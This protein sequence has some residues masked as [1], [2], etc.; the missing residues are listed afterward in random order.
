MA[1][2]LS[3]AQGSMALLSSSYMGPAAGTAADTVG[4]I[5]DGRTATV[6]PGGPP[7][8][9]PVSGGRPATA[10]QRQ[11][12]NTWS[13]TWR[14]PLPRVRSRR[15]PHGTALS[16]TRTRKRKRCTPTSGDGGHRRLSTSPRHHR[17]RNVC[18]WRHR[19]GASSTTNVTFFVRCR[20]RGEEAATG[21][22]GERGGGGEARG[23]VGVASFKPARRRGANDAAGWL[24]ASP[25]GSIRGAGA[26]SAGGGGDG[27]SPPVAPS[28]PSL[29]HCGDHGALL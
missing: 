16:V 8:G 17:L 29:D 11:N 22:T 10:P 28:H 25:T 6:S 5:Q 24:A 21:T 7:A 12:N 27:R 13:S 15:V 20:R 14:T 19:D 9:Q 18:R 3:A 23:T 4:R 26:S 1:L 2:L